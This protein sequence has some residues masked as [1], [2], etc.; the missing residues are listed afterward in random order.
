MREVVDSSLLVDL[1]RAAVTRGRRAAEA[2][3][4]SAGDDATKS[5]AENIKDSAQ[6]AY[7]GVKHAAEKMNPFGGKTQGATEHATRSTSDKD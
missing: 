2:G 6:A 1:D 7:E 5:T 3:A 4:A